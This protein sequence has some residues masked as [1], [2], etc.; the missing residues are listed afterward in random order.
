VKKRRDYEYQMRR[1]L[2]RKSDYLR[3]LEYEMN[4]EALRKLRKVGG[5]S[6]GSSGGGS[7]SSSSGS[8]N[9]LYVSGV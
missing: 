6:S 7:S 8:S 1:K 4:L 2:A 3:Y 5:S 9:A